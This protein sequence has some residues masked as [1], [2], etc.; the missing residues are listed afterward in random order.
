MNFFNPHV[1]DILTTLQSLKLRLDLGV[2]ANGVTVKFRLVDCAV[3][4]K[5]RDSHSS[6][7]L[8][9]R[10]MQGEVHSNKH[11][12]FFKVNR[13]RYFSILRVDYLTLSITVEYSHAPHIIITTTFSEEFYS[14]NVL[15][16]QCDRLPSVSFCTNQI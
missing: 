4:A 1:F 2:E 7:F 16:M 15:F 5:Y 13:T 10:S 8:V 6:R 3:G 14:L 9:V 12:T 11:I